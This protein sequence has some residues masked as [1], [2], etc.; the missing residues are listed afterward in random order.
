MSK[1]RVYIAGPYTHKDK[2]IQERRGEQHCEITSEFLKNGH[3]TYS[4]IAETMNLAKYGHMVGTTWDTWRE[5][6]QKEVELSDEMWILMLDGWKD[7]VGVRGEVKHCIRLNKPISLYDP[8]TKLFWEVTPECI[9]G[10]LGVT[11]MEEL[12]D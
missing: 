3:L 9:L 12:N 7:S 6:D 10:E 8:T 1:P 4:P 2:A 11:T 5:K